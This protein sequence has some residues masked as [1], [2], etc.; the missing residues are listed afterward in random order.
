[1]RD[2]LSIL[3][4]SFLLVYTF[5]GFAQISFFYQWQVVNLPIFRTVQ[6]KSGHRYDQEHE[7]TRGIA[8][9]VQQLLAYEKAFGI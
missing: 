8:L 5:P 6:C 9:A 1:L 7:G 4:P 2:S 3:I